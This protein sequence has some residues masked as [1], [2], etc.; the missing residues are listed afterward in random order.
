MISHLFSGVSAG[1]QCIP[2]ANECSCRNTRPWIGRTSSAE[3]S[4][5]GCEMVKEG[6]QGR[7][8]RAQPDVG[9]PAAPLHLQ[10]RVTAEPTDV[11]MDEADR[12]VLASPAPPGDAG[13]ADGDVAA[14]PVTCAL[15]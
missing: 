3:T 11:H 4:R 12:L 1:G 14:E 2:T 6:V 15:G 10:R 8:R 13:H 7:D 5:L 9:T